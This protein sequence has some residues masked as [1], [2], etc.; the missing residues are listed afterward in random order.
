[1][2]CPFTGLGLFGGFRGNRWL[3]NRIAVFKQFVVPSLLAQTSQNFVLWVS[4]RP[5]DKYNPHVLELAKYLSE[6]GLKFV[7]TCS[8]VAFW[9]DKYSDEI[10]YNRLIDALQGSIGELTDVIGEADTVLMTIQPS[11]DC[12]HRE[13]VEE[14]QKAFAAENFQAMG[15]T[16]GYMMNYLDKTLCEYNPTTIPPFFTIKFAADIF[17]DPLKHA[18]YTGPYKSHE[19]VGDKLKFAA[20]HERGFIVGTH[21]YNI[22]TFFDNPFKGIMV[23]QEILKDFGL[24]DIEP[25][26][27]HGSFMSI[28]FHK[29]PHNFKRKLRYWAG[30]KKWILKPFFVIIYNILR[31]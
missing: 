4:W 13:F 3:K 6:T 15:F 31:S 5:E 7:F 8:G 12:Y 25:I 23:D 26:K 21:G 10:A 29:L 18:E 30:E 28:L 17:K 20:I 16:M 2:Y 11:D 24:Y 19:Y 1:M 9:D 27:I 14:I 22:S